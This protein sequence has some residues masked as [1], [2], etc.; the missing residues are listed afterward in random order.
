MKRD[1]LAAQIL[2]RADLPI[3]IAILVVK[4][5]LKKQ[6]MAAARTRHRDGFTSHYA[7]ER[8]IHENVNS[9]LTRNGHSGASCQP[10]SR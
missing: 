5:S 1:A 4:L 2:L 9:L 6:C 8:I 3:L 7:Y 10:G